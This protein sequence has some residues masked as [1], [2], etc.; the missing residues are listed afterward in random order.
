[1]SEFL[2]QTTLFIAAC[3]GFANFKSMGELRYKVWVAKISNK[4]LQSAQKLKLLP[5][6]TEAFV[7]HV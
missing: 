4:N 3:Y 2:K 7:E 1:M 6:A 5:P